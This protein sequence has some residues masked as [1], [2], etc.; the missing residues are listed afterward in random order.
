TL[1][2]TWTPNFHRNVTLAALGSRIPCGDFAIVGKT[3]EGNYGALIM[4]KQSAADRGSV[5]T[6]IDLFNRMRGAPGYIFDLRY[7]D[8]GD[9]SLARDIAEL[10]C[11]KDTV[12]A[13]SRFR[14]GPGLGDFGPPQDRILKGQPEALTQPIV[15]LIGPGA[16]SSGEGFVK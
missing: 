8:G 15:V 11:V 10:F 14:N 16:V 9:E 2:Q 7:A 4:V 6:A 3:L 13:R 5:R 12:Y 1:F